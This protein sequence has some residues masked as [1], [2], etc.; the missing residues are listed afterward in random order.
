VP[1]QHNMPDIGGLSLGRD[2]DGS[3]RRAHSMQPHAVVP[4]PGSL[5]GFGGG[6]YAGGPGSVMDGGMGSSMGGGMGPMG[7]M[8]G[9]MGGPMGGGME[10]YDDSGSVAGSAMTFMDGAMGGKTSQYGLPKYPHQAKPD[11]RR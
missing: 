1:N 9:G 4:S 11:P 6:G 5:A 3:R 10:G 8:S 7:G 2:R